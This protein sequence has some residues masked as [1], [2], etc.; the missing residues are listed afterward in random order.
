MKQAFMELEQ[1]E[2]KWNNDNIFIL[3]W[4]KPLKV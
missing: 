4:C 3:G 1:H 2:G